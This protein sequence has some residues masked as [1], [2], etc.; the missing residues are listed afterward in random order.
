MRSNLKTLSV[1]GIMARSFLGSTI[2]MK[3]LK[4]EESSFFSH[5]LSENMHTRDV[6]YN[7]FKVWLPRFSVIRY[8][9]A[10]KTNRTRNFLLVS[11]SLFQYA[12]TLFYYDSVYGNMTWTLVSKIKTTASNQLKLVLE[13]SN[14]ILL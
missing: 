6:V 13:C 11:K 10:C 4:S 7:Y 8:I 1:K 9:C 2:K 14:D 5:H 3:I 12:N